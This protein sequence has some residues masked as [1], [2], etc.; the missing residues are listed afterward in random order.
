MRKL[1]AALFVVGALIGAG[2]YLTQRSMP[3]EMVR[4]PVSP[5]TWAAYREAVTDSK[6]IAADVLIPAVVQAN[7]SEVAGGADPRTSPSF[8][9]AANTV[10]T[11]AW[12][13]V[14]RTSPEA[15]VQ[16]GRQRG[17]ALI[18]AVDALLAW[19]AKS[20]MTL[21]AA[22]EMPNPAPPVSAYI[23]LGGG[24][25]RFAQDAGFI[26]DGRLRDMPFVQALFLRHWMAPLTQSMPLDAFVTRAERTWHLR[27]K[28]EAQAKGTLE[29]RL[30]AAEELRNVIGYPADLNAGVL[31]YEAGRLDEAR[32]RFKA[33]SEP[34][35][36]AYLRALAQ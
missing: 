3:I 10:R 1:I 35:A 29:S 25:V 2:W 34:Q 27:W 7:R 19:C 12:Q 16:L 21:E 4:A 15:F 36:D 13:F 28:V 26:V 17:V 24:F 20:G 14:Q 11:E 30:V 33:A 22:L 9:A 31:L 6:P 5:A 23:D 18:D 32:A 8:L